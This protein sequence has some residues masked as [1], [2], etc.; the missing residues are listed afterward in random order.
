MSFLVW[1]RKERY[2]P[3]VLPLNQ[4]MRIHALIDIAYNMHVLN[5]V[6]MVI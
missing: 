4:F 6:N 5:Y 1:I 2:L 3:D